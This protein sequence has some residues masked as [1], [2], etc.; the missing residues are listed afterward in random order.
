MQTIATLS[1]TTK[2]GLSVWDFRSTGDG[3]FYAIG[4]LKGQ[5]KFFKDVEQLNACLKNYMRYGYINS[6]SNLPTELQLALALS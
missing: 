1:K 5:R 4:G 2:Q 3:L 6:S